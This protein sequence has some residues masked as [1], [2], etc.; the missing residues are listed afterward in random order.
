MD[1]HGATPVDTL[2]EFAGYAIGNRLAQYIL[3]AG[4]LPA[5]LIGAALLR[6]LYLGYQKDAFFDLA[7]Y[8]LYVLFITFLVWPV[9]V[10]L[11]PQGPGGGTPLVSPTNPSVPAASADD[12]A[13]DAGSGSLKVPRLL[14][15]VHT[16]AD[17]IVGQAVFDMEP[18]FKEAAFA[19][20]RVAAVNQESRI[21]DVD[22]RERFTNYLEY[23]YQPA[24]A[25]GESAGWNNLPLLE[26]AST[27]RAYETL[28]LTTLAG[29]TLLYELEVP[30]AQARSG[31]LEDVRK[32]VQVD[33]FHRASLQAN[34]TFAT[35][36]GSPGVSA[37]QVSDFYLRR[38][39]YNEAFSQP[40]R[41]EVAMV[42][43]ALPEYRWYRNE[44]KA[45]SRE[46]LG[47]LASSVVNAVASLVE[48]WT[49]QALGPSTYYR[50]SVLAPYLYG[51][52]IAV[53]LMVFPVAGLMAFWPRGYLALVHYLK[54]FLSVK[55]WPLFWAFLSRMNVDRA[56]FDPSDPG[57]FQGT[58]G[59][60]QMF[61]SLAAMYLLV[62]VLSYL[63]VS[64]MSHGVQ[65]S[66]GPLLGAGATGT[67]QAAAAAS[68][69]ARAGAG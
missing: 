3:W 45:D 54:V 55:L 1:L 8:P 33:A 19:W 4:I 65:V 63:I 62:P 36:G 58:F 43:R 56:Q 38:V 20:Q 46:G 66:M 25:Q 42:R 34:V 35:K 12:P 31:L 2:Y 68:Q 47:W 61:T 21:F 7:A 67:G 16:L 32:H 18:N 6:L 24:V 5:L 28:G 51:L 39:L 64:V 23:C 17:L 11:T 49:E 53:L 29:T 50:I 44:F 69:I 26:A 15:V 37:A 57:G 40:G 13:V 14:A 48:W 22:L 41:N 9:D 10:G 27:L 60:S 30:C 52:I 59:E